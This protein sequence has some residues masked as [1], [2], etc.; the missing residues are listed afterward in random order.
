MIN[1]P[2]GIRSSR[3]AGSCVSKV[4]HVAARSY[5]PLTQ[6]SRAIATRTITDAT[7]VDAVRDLAWTTDEHTRVLAR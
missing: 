7:V 6:T 4:L 5:R 3:P 2:E 1:A